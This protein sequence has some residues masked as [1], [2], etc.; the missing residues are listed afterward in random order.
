MAFSPN[1]DEEMGERQISFRLWVINHYRGLKLTLTLTLVGIAAISW[2]YTLYGLADYWL[3]TGPK[4]QQALAE[5]SAQLL[6]PE[7]LAARRPREL[8]VDQPVIFST[9]GGP[10]SGGGEAGKYD[11]AVKIGNPNSNWYVEFNYQF[12]GLPKE[13]PARPGFILPGE[14]KYLMNLGVEASTIPAGIA[15]AFTN[16]KWHRIDVHEIPDYAKWSGDRLN[17]KISDKNFALSDGKL[18][19]NQL[20]FKIKNMTAWSFWNLDLAVLLFRGSS[21]ESVNYISLDKFLSGEERDVALS[22]KDSGL[23]PTDIQIQP[24]VNIFNPSVYMPPR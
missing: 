11:L 6:D 16:V 9:G 10:A 19:F 24:S 15:I 14:E 3:I 7:M 13:A 12:Q 1:N 18:T 2:G 4:E 22:W 21:L 23:S 20:D 5:I 8:A 17:F